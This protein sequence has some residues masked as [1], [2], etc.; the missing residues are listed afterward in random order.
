MIV[1]ASDYSSYTGR[2]YIYFGG[3]AM[4]NTADVTMTGEQIGDSFGISVS[5]AGDVN[6]D[7]YSDVIVGDGRYFT[8]G[9]AYIY[10]GGVS[11]NNI[12]DVTMTGEALG[13]FFGISV[14]SAGDVNGDGYSDVIVGASR[15][16]PSGRAYIYFGGVAMNNTADVIMTGE[17]LGDD[18][19]NSVSSAGDVNGDGYSDVIVG[20]GRYFTS[21][22]AYIYFGGV[23]MNNIADVTMTGETTNNYFGSS[24]SSAGDVNGD[25]YS[26]V[27]VGA[28]AALIT[29]DTGRAYIYFGGH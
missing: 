14:S 2:A 21:G 24:V 1:G 29:S 3:V 23:S 28:S 27:I 17:A 18:F 4:D 8:S 5:S 15:Y 22:R 11:M 20:D 19:G 26:D 13:D 25:G 16:F 6:G 12:A 7:G 10:F 9:R